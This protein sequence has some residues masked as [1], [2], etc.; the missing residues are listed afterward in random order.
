M[1]YQQA[2]IIF[3]WGTLVLLQWVG[4]TQVK[5]TTREKRKSFICH[6]G[7]GNYDAYLNVAVSKSQD[8]R[9]T[10]S[11]SHLLVQENQGFLEVIQSQGG[12]RSVLTISEV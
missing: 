6:I 3:E 10:G 11:I 8:K 12:S 2:C 5:Y 7:V 9:R 4:N 1:S